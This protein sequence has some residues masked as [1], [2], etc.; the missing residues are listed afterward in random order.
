MQMYILVGINFWNHYWSYV[1]LQIDFNLCKIIKSYFQNTKHT[2]ALFNFCPFV[3]S[4]FCQILCIARTTEYVSMFVYIN[5]IEN[6]NNK[7]TKEQ[8]QH[9]QKATNESST[10]REN[11][12]VYGNMINQYR[13][14]QRCSQEGIW[15]SFPLS[16]ENPTLL[17]SQWVPP[18]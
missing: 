14:M 12:C 18:L 9:A 1:L 5:I 6:G 11:V 4:V 7:P 10:Q 8:K 17:G 3:Y 15:G 2:I 13:Y 16:A